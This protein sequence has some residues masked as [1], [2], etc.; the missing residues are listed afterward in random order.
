MATYGIN[1]CFYCRLCENVFFLIGKR[2]IDVATLNV[3]HY[4]M[5]CIHG[6]TSQIGFCLFF[7]YWVF[8]VVFLFV[9]KLIY[10]SLNCWLVKT[11]FKH[12]NLHWDIFTKCFIWLT[13][14]KLIV[15]I[16]RLINSQQP[17]NKV[18]FENYLPLNYFTPW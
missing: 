13:M 16:A 15:S 7:S 8:A 12:H 14:V 5:Y 9:V 18:A 2:L 1:T 3:N 17:Y 11:R 10:L 4:S 6:E